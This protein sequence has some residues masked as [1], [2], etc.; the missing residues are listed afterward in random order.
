MTHDQ[1]FT[2]HSGELYA[3]SVPLGELARRF[4]TPAVRVFS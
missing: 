3:E 1:V 2:E 4:G